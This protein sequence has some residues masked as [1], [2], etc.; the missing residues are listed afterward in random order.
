MA[1]AA[2]ARYHGQRGLNSRNV[3]FMVLEARSPRSWA[4]WADVGC[5][6]PHPS[7]VWCRPGALRLLHR[8]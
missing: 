6:H 1:R 5:P 4:G 3:F 8:S 7:T 2:G